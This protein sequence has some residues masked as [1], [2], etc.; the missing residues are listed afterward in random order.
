MKK[1]ILG[2]L[3]AIALA[4]GIMVP[5][6][7][8]ESNWTGYMDTTFS[9]SGDKIT[10][11]TD[12][13]GIINKSY[14]GTEITED[15]TS[16]SVNVELDLESL[17][18]S[19]FTITSNVGE[20]EGNPEYP[21]YVSD[22]QIITTVN[23][24]GAII[25]SPW[26]NYGDAIEINESGIYTYTWTFTKS[27]DGSVTGKFTIDNYGQEVGELVSAYEFKHADTG[28]KPT[29]LRT[30]WIYGG[31]NN[32]A[33]RPLQK[34]LNIWTVL[35]TPVTPEDNEPSNGETTTDTEKNPNTSDN[36]ILYVALAVIGLSVVGITTKSL[37]K[38]N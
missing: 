9:I 22:F 32:D 37:I 12:G 25:T 27:N 19:T 38:N 8:A 24:D 21:N 35:P 36:I 26:T 4:F 1:R 15:G 33:Q 34:A 5:T 11:G 17:K 29:V 30:M 31:N 13:S 7:S 18:D 23:E 6:V 2:G 10:I 20:E 28:V 3:F 16:M 14:A